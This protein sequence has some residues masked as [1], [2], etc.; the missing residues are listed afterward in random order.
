MRGYVVFLR[1]PYAGRL[2]GGTLLG[3]LPNG[4]GMLA[5]VLHIRADGGG[6]P[7]AG[8]LA[9]V[10]GLATAAGQPVLGRV[11]DRAGQPRVLVPAACAAAA[12]FA[13]LAAVG[14]D[15]LPVSVA[16]VVAA[17]FATPPLEAGL[18]ALWPD[19][20]DGPEQVDAAYALDAAAQ[21]VIF[22]VGPLLV[23]AAALVNTETAL[24]ITGALGIAGTLVVAL[25][26]PS[27]RWRGAPR[28]SDWAGP[29]R[30]PGLRVL[31]LS[32]ACAGVALGV[33]AVAVVAYAEEQGR[34]LASGLLLACMA[35]GA[36]IGGIVYGARSWAGEPHHRLPWL[37]AALAAGYVPLVLAPGLPVMSV[38]AFLS[39]VFLAPVLAC[40]FSLV[41]RLA[42]SGTVTEAFAWVVAAVGAGGSLGSFVSGIGQD[43]AGVP[44]AFAGAGAGGVLALLL[45]MLGG[46]T[47]RPVRAAAVTANATA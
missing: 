37:L 15:P 40:S 33:Y 25:S 4:M 12:G 30:S 5:V 46:R 7:L 45:C 10:F 9:A 43:L 29:L 17:G 42:P 41:D 36:L 18:R 38:L 22:T 28:A 3:R 11:M 21:E 27:R 47:L 2:L 19:V 16:A 20:L 14:A 44:G 1:R 8:T 23:V 31:L 6:Y 26:G 32:L 35:G 24:L 13:L 34:D 39:G